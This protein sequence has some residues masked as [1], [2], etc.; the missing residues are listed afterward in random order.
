MIKLTDI[1][2]EIK[3]N[4]PFRYEKAYGE[5]H[6][7]DEYLQNKEKLQDNPDNFLIDLENKK[8][9]A[10]FT[11]WNVARWARL[12]EK[13]SNKEIYRL[14]S[15]TAITNPPPYLQ[16]PHIDINDP[17]SW[18][19]S[20]IALSLI[21]K[22]NPKDLEE[23]KISV[24]YPPKTI[25]W[26]FSKFPEPYRTQAIK[27]WKNHKVYKINPN[28]PL[29]DNIVAALSGAFV[30]EDTPEGVTYWLNLSVNTPL[31]SEIKINP[32]KNSGWYHD[33]NRMTDTRVQQAWVDYYTNKIDGKKLK[34]I[35]LSICKNMMV[36]DGFIQYINNYNDG[37]SEESLPPSSSGSFLTGFYDFD[38]ET[39]DLSEEE[40][41]L[42]KDRMKEA[43]YSIL[44]KIKNNKGVN[45]IKVNKPF[46]PPTHFP[47]IV[48]KKEY[49]QV[50]E[51]LT[52]MGYEWTGET[53]TDFNEW[54]PWDNG[55][56]EDEESKIYLFLKN[57][58]IIYWG[59]VDNIV[60]RELT[61]TPIK[62]F[63]KVN[64]NQQI[65]NINYYQQILDQS[66]GLSITQRQYFQ[67]II[68]SI[69]KQNNKV[70]P[71][72]HDLLQRIKSGNF[73]YSTK[74]EIKIN[75]PN[76][77]I[78]KYP[79]K[80]EN[81]K[82]LEKFREK[83]WKIHWDKYK[84]EYIKKRE[85]NNYEEYIKDVSDLSLGS[86]NLKFPYYI[87]LYNNYPKKTKNPQ[88]Q[89]SLSYILD[90]IKTLPKDKQQELRQILK[91]KFNIQEIKVN[92]PNKIRTTWYEEDGLYDIHFGFNIDEYN[93]YA[94]I[95]TNKPDEVNIFINRDVF[96]GENEYHNLRKYLDKRNIK[97]NI[98]EDADSL[99]ITLDKDNFNII[100]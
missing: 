15:K 75:Q 78:I 39:D 73:T 98:D 40:Q 50:T 33:I 76:S 8:I 100:K 3:V 54:N 7:Y 9:I 55:G 69:K 62:N 47:I 2:F 43:Y 28:G 5:S 64:E 24:P 94:H 96:S 89:N 22:Y 86:E 37:F 12:A 49:S 57:K 21:K 42:L 74:N 27:N 80:I 19:S 51:Y 60:V 30:W 32:P 95:D 92:N 82:D 36:E 84:E 53:Y 61:P 1:L 65:K 46:K 79:V 10:S 90:K 17:N 59:Y 29:F 6:S 14:V 77:D 91:D 58:N 31:L 52:K 18:E 71:R 13:D 67:K 88:L 20:N 44:Y 11:G 38:F 81:E 83:F 34:Q 66:N 45:E 87:V 23:I 4:K 48:N 26:W 63:N 70:T 93:Y 16:T 35:I 25:G 99:F 41:D 72:Q 68:N 97:Y 85:Y 56:V